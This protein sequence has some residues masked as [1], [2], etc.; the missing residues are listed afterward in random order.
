LYQGGW[1]AAGFN[2]RRFAQ[3]AELRMADPWDGDLAVLAQ[4][5]AEGRFRADYL[6]NSG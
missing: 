2:L 1:D 3:E 4:A 5:V 6:K